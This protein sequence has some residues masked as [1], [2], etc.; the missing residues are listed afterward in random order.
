MPKPYIAITFDTQL[1]FAMHDLTEPIRRSCPSPCVDAGV[2]SPTD[3]HL[4]VYYGFH[5][6]T[7]VA[8]LQA[9][10]NRRWPKGRILQLCF[11]QLAYHSDGGC[12]YLILSVDSPSIRALNLIL[13]QFPGA[14]PSEFPVYSPHVTLATVKP[15]YFLQYN[16]SESGP[17]HPLQTVIEPEGLWF[18]EPSLGKPIG[19]KTWTS[20]ELPK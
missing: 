15:D 8:D 19:H 6:T 1:A 10:I 13:S 3:L 12:R 5:S 4:T 2:V 18:V 16:C 11:S 20:L 17:R 7:R 9:H 14:L